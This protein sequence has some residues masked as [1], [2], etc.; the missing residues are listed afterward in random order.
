MISIMILGEMDLVRGAL[1]ARLAHED[2]LEVVSVLPLR[3][4]IVPVARERCPAVVIVDIDHS[5]GDA[6][7][8]AGRLAVDV[9]ECRVVLLAG[10][11]PAAAV[12]QVLAAGVSGLVSRDTAPEQLVRAIRQVV[13]GERVIDPTMAAAALH[14]V[15]SPLTDQEQAVLLLAEDG[16]RAPEIAE[17]LFLSRGTVRNYLSSAVRKTGARNRLE[18]ARSARKCG[19]M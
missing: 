3:E 2:D 9:P 16:L 4:D 6:M 17:R 19:W 10:R 1:A 15:A 11:E 13:A 8:V 12:H 5:N 7:A 14:P 18:A